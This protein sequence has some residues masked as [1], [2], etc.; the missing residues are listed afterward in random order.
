MSED[1]EIKKTCNCGP[2][3]DCGCQDGEECTCDG[4]CECG[5][6]CEDCDCGGNE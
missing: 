6:D 3:C 1:I 4:S 2:E 5:C